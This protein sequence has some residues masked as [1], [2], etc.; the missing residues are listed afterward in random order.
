ME[1]A[2]DYTV[3]NVRRGYLPQLV[4]SGQASLQSGAPRLPGALADVL[5]ANGYDYTGMAKDQY[6][7]VLDL[8]Q[9]VWDGGDLAARRE[10]AAAEGRVQKARTTV[11]L[12]D[13]RRQVDELFFGILLST[14]G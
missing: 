1:Q 12:Y 2:T 9:V 14:S 11:G 13:V 5:Q 3:A 10:V 8:S 6:R 4:L 7:V